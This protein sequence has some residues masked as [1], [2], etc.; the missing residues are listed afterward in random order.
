MRD[1][2]YQECD[3]VC[4]DAYETDEEEEEDGDMKVE[5]EEVED[6]EDVNMPDPGWCIHPRQ[7]NET[8]PSIIKA[9]VVS[10]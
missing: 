10:R 9:T 6:E 1:W 4:A 3:A 5:N 8:W 7:T 2:V